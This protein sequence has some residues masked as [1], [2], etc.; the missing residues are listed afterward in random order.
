MTPGTEEILEGAR[1]PFFLLRD[2]LRLE[3]NA[4][5]AVARDVEL[6]VQ[7]PG[8]HPHL[9]I[10]GRDGVADDFD[11]VVAGDDDD[12]RGHVAEIE[13]EFLCLREGIKR[14]VVS[15]Y[16]IFFYSFA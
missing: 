6:H 10:L 12:L 1:L 3:P 5:F 14:R 9:D 8:L 4:D 13:K 2:G 11:C 7:V 15:L 16:S